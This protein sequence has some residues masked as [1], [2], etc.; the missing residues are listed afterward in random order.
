M[1]KPANEG[2]VTR[3]YLGH[4]FVQTE[5]RLVDCALSSRLRKQL[6]YP[7][8]A[9]GSRRQRVQSVRRV[10]VIDPVAIGDRVIFDPGGDN[11]TGMIR[12]VC[13]RRNKISR[14]ASG[15]SRK[16]QLIAA[17][18]D[19]VVPIFSA[20]EPKPGWHL[21]DRMLAIAEWQNI[22]PAICFNKQ[23]LTDET[24][25]H[26]T[27]QPYEAIGYPV[28]YTSIIS[29]TGKEAF[30]D[31]LT[32]RVTLFM[33]PSGVGKS[34]LLNWLQPGLQLRTGQISEAS[35]EGKHTTSH[36]ELVAL[37]GGGLV[38]DIPGVREF[39]LFGITPEDIP[40]LFREFRPH[41]TECR[42]RDCTHIH[43]PDCAVK[44]ALD[45]GKITPQRYQSYLRLR[46]KP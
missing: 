32:G 25:A 38:G 36:T 39:Y 11:N 2:I 9:P 5:D 17:N 8:A 21:L 40:E 42:F 15:G 28:V 1:S 41:I 45:A 22:P 12:E 3:Q 43:E 23:D 29:N 14:R 20:A 31:L 24:R 16:E 46:E 27:M 44:T 19:Q 35:G 10:R 26:Q 6:Q 34:S 7:E 33:G 13:A 30:R 4:Y 18:I 37:D